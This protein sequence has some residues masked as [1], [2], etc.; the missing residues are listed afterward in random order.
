GQVHHNISFPME[1]AVTQFLVVT[2][3][4]RL[5]GQKFLE[6]LS[7]LAPGRPTER[8]KFIQRMARCSS[9]RPWRQ[10]FEKPSAFQRRKIDNVLAKRDADARFPFT[11]LENAERQI[12]QRKIRIA[13]NVDE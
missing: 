11:R 12:L 4:R 6:N 7:H 9:R 8:Q 2:Q 5:S 1:N 13:L 10:I 3:R